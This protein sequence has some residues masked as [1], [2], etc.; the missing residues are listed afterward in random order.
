MP[1]PKLHQI[2]ELLHERNVI[3]ER[4]AAIIN[5]PMTAGHLGEWIAARIF[6]IELEPSV[7]AAAIDGRFTADPSPHRTPP[8]ATGVGSSGGVS[9]STCSTSTPPATRSP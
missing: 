8:T 7:V 2:A 1:D 3:D 5:R 6:G 4:I 9:S